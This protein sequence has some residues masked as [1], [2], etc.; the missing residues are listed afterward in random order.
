MK[1]TWIKLIQ[2]SFMPLLV[3]PSQ[4]R[5][6]R[7]YF[8]NCYGTTILVYL[9]FD[10]DLSSY[11]WVDSMVVIH[12]AIVFFDSVSWFFFHAQIVWNNSIFPYHPFPFLEESLLIRPSHPH[13]LLWWW[14]FLPFIYHN[15]CLSVFL[16][17]KIQWHS[18]DLL[19]SGSI[20]LCIY[21][22]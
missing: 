18:F 9:S 15:S 12:N 1:L 4:F 11:P 7:I 13:L 6:I 5:V 17:T 19:S 3:V 10:D 8:Y 14:L 22:S 16:S 21:I 20:N 2:L